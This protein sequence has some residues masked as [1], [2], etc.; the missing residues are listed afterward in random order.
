MTTEQKPE[1]RNVGLSTGLGAAMQRL[2][3][4]CIEYAGPFDDP[5]VGWTGSGAT[6]KDLFRCERCGAEHLDCFAIPHADGCSAKRLLDALAA[7][8]L[9]T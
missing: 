4:A 2:A 3:V 1:G 6:H 7:V 9:N 5:R 8:A